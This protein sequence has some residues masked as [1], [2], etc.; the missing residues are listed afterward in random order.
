MPETASANELRVMVWVKAIIAVV[1][2]GCVAY[3]VITGS[4]VGDKLLALITTILVGYFGYSAKVYNDAANRRR[5]QDQRVKQAIERM[6][7]GG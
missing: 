5:V 4:A 3:L 7:R 6:K 2:A 1:F